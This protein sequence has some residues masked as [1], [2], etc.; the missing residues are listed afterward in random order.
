VD[1]READGSTDLGLAQV[2]EI[3]EPDDEPLAAI[4]R[5]SGRGDERTGD[6]DIV[7]L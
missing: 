2:A 1:L 3:A 5:T 7:Q 6:A 4:E